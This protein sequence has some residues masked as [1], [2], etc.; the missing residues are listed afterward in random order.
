MHV[1]VYISA[2]LNDVRFGSLYSYEITLLLFLWLGYEQN[3][4]IVQRKYLIIFF[5]YGHFFSGL[6]KRSPAL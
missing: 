3:G 2:R 1:P 5:F 6:Q 4:Y